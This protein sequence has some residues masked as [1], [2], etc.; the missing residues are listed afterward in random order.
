MTGFYPV[1]YKTTRETTQ[2]KKNIFFN[3][4]CHGLVPGT[5]PLLF[6]M[7]GEVVEKV[8]GLT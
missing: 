6:V 4:L 3:L 7:E 8:V 1:L 2:E 5:Y